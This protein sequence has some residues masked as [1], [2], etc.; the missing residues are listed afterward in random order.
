V[1]LG[2]LAEQ[3]F[4]DDPNTCL[5]KLRQFGEV[6][7]QLAASNTGLYTSP[8]E[9]Q[10]D[11]L[12]RLRDEGITPPQIAQMFGELRRTGN[13]ATHALEQSVAACSRSLCCTST[14]RQTINVEANKKTTQSLATLPAKAMTRTRTYTT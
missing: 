12:Y 6:L 1:R 7:A 10:A 9:T 3:Y 13:A 11:L 2:I 8:Q 14:G 5:I 4:A